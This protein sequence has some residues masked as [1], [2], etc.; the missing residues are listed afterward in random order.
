M[1]NHYNETLAWYMESFKPILATC[2]FLYPMKTSES[3]RFSNVFK[4]YIERDQ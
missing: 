2:I 3:Q 4:G 1:T